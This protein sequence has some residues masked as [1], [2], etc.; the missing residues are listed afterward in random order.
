MTRQLGELVDE[1]ADRP[2]RVEVHSL[3]EPRDL[4][5][6]G[7][8]T[9]LLLISSC[10]LP[11]TSLVAA[12]SGPAA[13]HDSPST[14]AG[15]DLHRVDTQGAGGDTVD[16]ATAGGGLD[17]WLPTPPAFWPGGSASG[18]SFHS[19]CSVPLG[20]C[21]P[22]TAHPLGTSSVPSMVGVSVPGFAPHGHFRPACRRRAPA[23]TQQG[24]LRCRRRLCGGRRAPGRLPPAAAGLM[25]PISGSR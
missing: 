14:H 5:A 8:G 7:D 20:W 16:R 22:T 4:H 17:R 11:S 2:P 10:A 19:H 25:L 13:Y 1:T 21:G 6:S 3:H 12:K 23:R 15:I 18:A 9:V 24:S